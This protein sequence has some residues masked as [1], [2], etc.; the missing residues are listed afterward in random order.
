ML[1]VGKA[2]GGCGCCVWN[3]HGM[4]PLGERLPCESS[5]VE[6]GS[7]EKYMVLNGLL[8]LLLLL[9]IFVKHTRNPIQ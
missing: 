1:V 7:A 6:A 9:L 3:L 8:F 4:P 2:D 5:P